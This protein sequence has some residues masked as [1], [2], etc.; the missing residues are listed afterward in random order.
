LLACGSLPN[1]RPRMVRAHRLS[2]G[3]HHGNPGKLFVCHHCDNPACVRPDHLFIG[4]Q[5][6]NMRDM[7]RKGRYG[8]RFGDRRYQPT[9]TEREVKTIRASGE[10]HKALA[11]RFGVTMK[12]VCLIKR[13]AYRGRPEPAR[14]EM[15]KAAA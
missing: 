12:V 11:R 9:L 4:T 10:S 8:A 15:F 1:G 5:F 2:W 14:T 3:L 13:G 7:V 6:D